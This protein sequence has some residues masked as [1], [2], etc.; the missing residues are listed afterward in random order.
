MNIK[1]LL[2]KMI[3]LG[4]SDLHIKPGIAPVVRVNGKL[5]RMNFPAPT[6]REMEEV[7]RKMAK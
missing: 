6:P 5:Q 7:A 2:E 1:Q 4:A 3:E